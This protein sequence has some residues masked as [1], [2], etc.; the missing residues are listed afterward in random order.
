MF[1]YDKGWL[2]KYSFL[3]CFSLLTETRSETIRKHLLKCCYS[4]EAPET[5][6][7]DHPTPSTG[8]ASLVLP[9]PTAHREHHILLPLGFAGKARS[10]FSK[11]LKK[12]PFKWV[13]SK[14]LKMAWFTVQLFFSHLLQLASSWRVTCQNAKILCFFLPH[15]GWVFLRD[16]SIYILFNFGI[17]VLSSIYLTGEIHPGVNPE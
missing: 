15:L 4:S 12:K 1:L 9:P 6:Q 17:E 2:L 8:W 16:W 5:W 14:V 13:C 11:P 7:L 3:W 10:E